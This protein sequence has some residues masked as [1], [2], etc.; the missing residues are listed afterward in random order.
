MTTAMQAFQNHRPPC[1]DCKDDLNVTATTNDNFMIATC[2]CQ[3]C[4]L[5]F[6]AKPFYALSERMFWQLTTRTTPVRII[7]SYPIEKRRVQTE[8]DNQVHMQAEDGEQSLERDSGHEPD[9]G[10]GISMSCCFQDSNQGWFMVGL[11]AGIGIAL[12]IGLMG[13]VG[14]CYYTKHRH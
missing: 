4:H 1:P 8:R 2:T 3:V 13:V 14:G 6:D 12:C 7:E 10:F 11:L 5:E 9:A